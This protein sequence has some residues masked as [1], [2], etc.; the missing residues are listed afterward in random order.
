MPFRASWIRRSGVTFLSGASVFS[1]G[2][3]Q[4]CRAGDYPPFALG[5][6]LEGTD[7]S[8]EVI[9]RGQMGEIAPVATKQNLAQVDQAL[10][11]LFS[12]RHAGDAARMA[13]A[14]LPGAY[15]IAISEQSWQ[16]QELVRSGDVGALAP[17]ITARRAVGSARCRRTTQPQ[18]KTRQTRCEPSLR[19][20]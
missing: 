12:V 17:S 14:A 9:Q 16:A 10:P 15:F 7:A 20:R 4:T 2:D 3:R 8:G 1:I 11:V 6:A 5:Q 19:F 13:D 18:G